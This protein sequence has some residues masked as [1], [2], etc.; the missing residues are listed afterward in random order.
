MSASIFE[1]ENQI[2]TQGQNGQEIHHVN[3]DHQP[4]R[5]RRRNLR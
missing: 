1:A 4:S 2:L 5:P 3:A